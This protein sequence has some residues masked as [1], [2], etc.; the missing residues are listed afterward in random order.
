M[1]RNAPW[2]GIFG[3]M[4]SKC[5]HSAAESKASRKEKAPK[6]PP[7]LWLRKLVKGRAGGG[8]MRAFV[9][10]GGLAHGAMVE[11]V[12]GCRLWSGGRGG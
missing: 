6:N 1:F 12:L 8:R 4:Y 7:G 2:K 11:G 9:W 10:E 3:A 5:P